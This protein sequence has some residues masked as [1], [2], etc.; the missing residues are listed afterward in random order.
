MTWTDVIL[1][2]REQWALEGYCVYSLTL[3][4]FNGIS[5]W[6]IKPHQFSHNPWRLLFCTCRPLSKD[7]S[8]HKYH[9]ANICEEGRK[10]E[11]SS[12]L[13]FACVVFRGLNTYCRHAILKTTLSICKTTLSVDCIPVQ[14]LHWQTGCPTTEGASNAASN[15]ESQKIHP[16]EPLRPSYRLAGTRPLS[17]HTTNL[18]IGWAARDRLGGCFATLQ[19]AFDA[20][21]EVGQP[22][23]TAVIHQV[24]QCKFTLP[25]TPEFRHSP[26]IKQPT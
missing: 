22:C 26:W 11:I 19:A 25:S 6:L 3:I 10:Y 15:A 1:S 9:R 7:L 4:I 5:S 13:I 20:A 2:H 24:F 23:H 14:E 21:F 12:F 18:Q 16:I 8:C 17:P